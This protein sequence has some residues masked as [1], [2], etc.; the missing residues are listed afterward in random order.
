MKIPK[1]RKPVIDRKTARQRIRETYEDLWYPL[2]LMADIE[3]EEDRPE[4]AEAWRW[5]A[6][7]HKWP[8]LHKN[9]G[10][11]WYI[12]RD[13]LSP[14]PDDLPRRLGTYFR[15]AHNYFPTA[16]AAL[17]TAV[18]ALVSADSSKDKRP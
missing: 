10:W 2:L 13:R 7:N 4:Y 16:W 1:K 12:R 15:F 11:A 3:E 5:L 9:L 14:D 6:E 17:E 18:N 8:S